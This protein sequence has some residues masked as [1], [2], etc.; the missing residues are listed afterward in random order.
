MA[1]AIVSTMRPPSRP[2]V[3]IEDIAGADKNGSLSADLK[4]CRM[5]TEPDEA[6][7]QAW[8]EQSRRFF[9]RSDRKP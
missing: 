1:V 3:I 6:C 5:I 4:R 7:A 8:D 2:P 9:N